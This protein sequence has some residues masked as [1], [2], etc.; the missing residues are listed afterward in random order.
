MFL[1]IIFQWIPNQGDRSMFTG[2]GYS[3]LSKSL[4]HSPFGEF[5]PLF[6]FFTSSRRGGWGWATWPVVCPSV[7]SGSFILH[8]KKHFIQPN[9]FCRTF[10]F[11]E[12]ISEDA[13]WD[14]Q[15]SSSF[16]LDVK[17]SGFVQQI[18][19]YTCKK[20]GL[21]FLGRSTCGLKK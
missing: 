16:Y 20:C 15:W 9:F 2:R 10:T 19:F 8:K 18:E 3:H 12:K 4:I 11:V 17:T 5:V 6:H 1:K 21:N 14:R 13:D 7:L